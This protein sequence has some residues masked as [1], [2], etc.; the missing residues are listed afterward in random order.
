M[1]FS[2]VG[3]A[4]VVRAPIV[5]VNLHSVCGHA[6]A[7]SSYAGSGHR[8]AVGVVDVFGHF[9]VVRI[10]PPPVF[11]FIDTHLA[12]DIRYRISI[13]VNA[14]NAELVRIVGAEPSVAG[15][16]L[17]LFNANVALER[18]VR[19]RNAV[20]AEIARLLIHFCCEAGAHLARRVGAGR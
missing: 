18:R 1:A 3:N 16:G 5:T 17:R 4:Y 15:V 14:D 10:P 7:V 12:L 13:V 19:H 20:N 2:C 11:Q 9:A 6:A 8:L